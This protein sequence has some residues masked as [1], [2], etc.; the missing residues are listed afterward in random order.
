MDQKDI[1]TYAIIILGIIIVINIIRGSKKENYDASVKHIYVD[2]D[3]YPVGETIAKNNNKKIIPVYRKKNCPIKITNLDKV[4]NNTNTCVTEIIQTPNEFQ[5]DFYNFRDKT[6][7]NSSMRYDPVDKVSSL[8]LS[9]NLSDARG[10]GENVKIKDLFDNATK[11]PVN[12]YSRS[13]VRIPK[14]D[15]VNPDGYYLNEGTP[16]L[17]LT[18]DEWTY[19]NENILNGGSMDGNI[20]PH[21]TFN[22]ENFELSK[23]DE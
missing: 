22:T 11:A 10:Y 9:G 17:H 1:I 7:N 12:L 18:R 23:Y 6:Q 20:Y 2:K 14:F 21:E 16:G 3:Y 8:Y 19:D 4:D 15:N 13:C 5:E